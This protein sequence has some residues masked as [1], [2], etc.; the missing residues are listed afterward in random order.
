[1][2]TTFT[3]GAHHPTL[4]VVLQALTNLLGEVTHTVLI[5]ASSWLV[6]LVLLSQERVTDRVRGV[7]LGPLLP[8]EYRSHEAI[9]ELLESKVCKPHPLTMPTHSLHRS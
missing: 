7:K 3:G 8:V 4:L 5:I 2:T 1:M 6:Y 9:T